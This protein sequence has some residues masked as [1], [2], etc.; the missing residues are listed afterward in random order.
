[1]GVVVKAIFQGVDRPCEMIFFLLAVQ[2]ATL[3]RSRKRWF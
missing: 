1:L 3:S 2:N